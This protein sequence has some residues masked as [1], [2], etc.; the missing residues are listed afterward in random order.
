MADI[1]RDWLTNQNTGLMLCC[2]WF[3]YTTIPQSFATAKNR[4][5]LPTKV[6]HIGW[7]LADGREYLFNIR[8]QYGIL[9]NIYIH[10]WIYM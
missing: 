6:R 9:K 7:Q 10:P 5:S 1:R 2:D 3:K 4:S 8:G